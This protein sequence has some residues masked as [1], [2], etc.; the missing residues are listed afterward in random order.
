MYCVHY[1]CRCLASGVGI[2]TLGLGGEGNALCPVFSSLFFFHFIISVNYFP[3]DFV[4]CA[5]VG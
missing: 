5:V 4:F 3:V 1:L 2:L